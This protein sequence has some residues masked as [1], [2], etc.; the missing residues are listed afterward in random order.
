MAAT[1]R[2]QEFR[3]RLQPT[4]KEVKFTLTRI[5]KSPLSIIG[6]GLITFFVVLAIIAPVIAPA[7]N[8]QT[9][10]PYESWP[11]WQ[12]PRDGYT[13]IPTPPSPEHPLGTTEGQWD[14]YYGLIW[15]TRN[16]FRVGIYV[17]AAALTIGLLVGIVS[18]FFGGLID[19]ILMRF[20]DIVLAFPG[21]ILAM[22]FA[23]TLVPLGFPTLDAVLLA[24]IIVGWPGYTRLIRGEILRVKSEDYVEAARAIGCSKI[25]IMFRHVLPNVIYPI[26]VVASLDIGSI[27]LTAAALAFLGIGAP[28][29]FA[30]WGQ[31]ISRSRNWILGTTTDPFHFWYVYIIP[32]LFIS[33][34]VLGWSLLGDAFRDILDPTLRRR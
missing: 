13:H 21:L 12:I 10:Q 27:V 23:V 2:M 28:P 5:R 6:A 25:R 32:G 26:I 4:I 20:T 11:W 17:V 9:G 18:G 30:D 22:A 31:I 29:D 34:F 3:L 7:I 14:L 16:A 8:F 33:F 1:S 15:G 24:L 19:E